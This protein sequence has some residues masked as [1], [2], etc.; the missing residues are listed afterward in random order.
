MMKDIPIP[1]PS[2]IFIK[3]LVTLII[4]VVVKDGKGI[5]FTIQCFQ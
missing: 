5:L 2:Y 1:N 4:N 3:D